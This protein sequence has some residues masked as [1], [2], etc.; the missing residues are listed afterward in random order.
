MGFTAA[1][2]P[3]LTSKINARLSSNGEASKARED[4]IVSEIV[5]E[6]LQASPPRD[7]PQ[8]SGSSNRRA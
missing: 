7:V 4:S 2:Y 6:L 3:V 8:A 5:E 1:Q